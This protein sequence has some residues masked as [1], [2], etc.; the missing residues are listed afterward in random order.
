[1]TQRPCAL[2]ELRADSLSAVVLV[3]RRGVQEVYKGTSPTRKRPPP[4][5]HHLMRCIF[6]IYTHLHTPHTGYKSPCAL[7]LHDYVSLA[8]KAHTIPCTGV[9]RP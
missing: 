5:D 7:T 3:R 1:M 6:F 8:R 4:Y 9:A 2:S